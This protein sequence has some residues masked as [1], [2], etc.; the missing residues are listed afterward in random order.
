MADSL[1]QTE[2]V[3]DPAERERVR[4]EADKAREEADAYARQVE[5]IDERTRG[6]SRP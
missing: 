6:P 5:L 2:M 3:G 1:R 4:L